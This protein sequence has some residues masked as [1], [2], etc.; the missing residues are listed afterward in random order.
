MLHAEGLLLVKPIPMHSSALQYKNYASIDNYFD[1]LQYF[2]YLYVY[3]TSI[4]VAVL[5]V[6]HNIQQNH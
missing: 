3:I 2:I 1:N 5:W 6:V 4:S